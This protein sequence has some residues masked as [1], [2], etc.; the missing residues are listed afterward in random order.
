M[1]EA[2]T[3]AGVRHSDE[4]PLLQGMRDS[5]SSF[6]EHRHG[7][8]VQGYF[9]VCSIRAVPVESEHICLN[10]Y[11]SI[12]LFPLRMPLDGHVPRG[13]LAGILS[14]TVHSTCTLAFGLGWVL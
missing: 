10:Y 6:S 9:F 4:D 3:A 5:R 7:W 13:A 14:V 8:K 1:P 2:S 12:A 11:L